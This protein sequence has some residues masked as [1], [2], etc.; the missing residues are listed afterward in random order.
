M[1]VYLDTITVALAFWCLFTYSKDLFVEKS[2]EVML[3]FSIPAFYL[4]AQSSWTSAWLVGD[5]WGRD[6]ANYVWFI[7]N[8]LVF[9]ALI[10]KRKDT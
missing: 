10:L 5:V 7:F 3:C 8:T 4:L 2:F 1:S 6:W 9:T